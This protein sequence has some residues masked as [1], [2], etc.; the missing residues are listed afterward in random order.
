VHDGLWDAY[1]P[2]HMG[3]VAEK[4]ATKYGITR[5]QQDEYATISYQRS[6]TSTNAGHFKPEI[7]AVEIKSTK[8]GT[9]SVVVTKDDEPFR[10]DF[11]K[12][13]SLPPSFD[14]KGTITAANASVISD[15]ACA[16]VLMS[17]Q[18]ANA[19]GLTPIAVIRGFS[20]AASD[21]LAY[22]TAPALAIPIALKNAGVTQDQIDLF[23][24]NEAFSV[25][26]LAN[27]K[28]LGIPLDQMNVLGGA[29]SLGHPIGCSGARILITL[30]TALADRNKKFGCA[31]I[32]NGGGG[33]SALVLERCS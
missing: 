25:V 31:G 2:L 28:L 15:G 17:R 22:P 16:L 4:T 26:V 21:P 7:T 29:V 14:K 27:M 6:Q 18:K 33:A 3:A 8:P 10:V 20:D 30:I 19:L 23:E 1:E 9:K 13:P 5:Q 12:L 11:A 32:C 24:I